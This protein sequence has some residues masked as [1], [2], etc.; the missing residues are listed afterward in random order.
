MI[1]VI[2]PKLSDKRDPYGSSVA[3]ETVNG[4]PL[5]HVKSVSVHYRLNEVVTAE[6]TVAA[7]MEEVWALPFMSEQSF[8]DAAK[9]YGYKVEKI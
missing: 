9:R 2:P 5:D 7:H 4:E 3:L 1:K 6:I 8:L